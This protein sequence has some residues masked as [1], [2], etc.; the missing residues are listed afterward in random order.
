[1]RGLA[2]V[3]REALA[4]EERAYKISKDVF[5]ETASIDQAGTG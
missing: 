1:V 5:G 3:R 4:L 2:R